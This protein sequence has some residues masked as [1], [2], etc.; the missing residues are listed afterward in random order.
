MRQPQSAAQARF[1]PVEFASE[2]AT[3][4]GRL[5]TPEGTA[6]PPH[7]LVVMAPG[8]SATVCMA[9]DRHA[10]ALTARG[11]AVLLYDHRNTGESGGEPRRELNAW[12]QA[13]LP[14]RGAL[15][16]LVAA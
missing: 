13:R 4:R 11:L 12:V 7:P 5:Y 16:A 9:F 2:G 14:R 1:R 3:L 15:R 6:A 8:S 10:E